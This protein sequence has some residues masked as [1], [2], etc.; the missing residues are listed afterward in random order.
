M[1]CMDDPTDELIQSIAYGRF[2][3]GTKLLDGSIK[4]M[5]SSGDIGLFC[6]GLLHK[7]LGQYGDNFNVISGE[8]ALDFQTNDGVLQGVLTTNQNVSVCLSN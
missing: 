6:S 2:A 1:K 4:E 8:E 7:L 5:D 3:K